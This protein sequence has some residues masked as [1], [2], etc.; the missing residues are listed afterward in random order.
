MDPLTLTLLAMTALTAATTV[1][2]GDS[3]TAVVVALDMA[4]DSFDDQYR[5]CGRAMAAALPA[6]NHSELRHGAAFAEAWALAAAEW[7]VRLSPGSPGSP[8]SPGSPLS[9]AQAV[10]LLAYTAPVPLHREFNA[11]VRAAGRSRREYRDNFHFK[12]LHFLLTQALGT[13]RAAQGSRCHR[14]FRGVRGVRFEARRGDTVRFGHFASAS[15]R[16]ESSWGFGTDAAFQVLTCQG[17]AIREFSFFPHEEEVLIPPF[18]TFEVTDVANVTKS[19]DKARIQL[20]ST[21]TFSNYNCE[22]LRADQRCG[23][24]PCVFDAGRNIP[25]DLPHLGGL[26]L[27]TA[28]LAVATGIC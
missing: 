19:G 7:R 11:A 21:G 16:N 2:P 12:T 23:D 9:P 13:L 26:L 24:G 14:V 6:L 10:A 3:A 5:G 17:A 25:G 22:W 18:E 15:L 28:A 1:P 27:A 8:R 20:R 4:R